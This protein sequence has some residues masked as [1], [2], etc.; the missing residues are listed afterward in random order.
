MK[1]CTP[2]ER[3]CSLVAGSRKDLRILKKCTRELQAALIEASAILDNLVLNPAAEISPSLCLRFCIL[4][5]YFAMKYQEARACAV[6]AL[7]NVEASLAF[8]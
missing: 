2:R 4:Q 6:A 7:G 3:T 8:P 5:E 1:K